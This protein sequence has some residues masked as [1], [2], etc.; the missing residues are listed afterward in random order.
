MVS[1]REEGGERGE[2]ERERKREENRREREG[3]KGPRGWSPSAYI[4][5]IFAPP[6]EN[7]V[8]P[9]KKIKTRKTKKNNFKNLEARRVVQRGSTGPRGSSCSVYRNRIFAPMTKTP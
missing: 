5:R 8:K 3:S 9:P 1:L 7:P 6:D 2:R 4:N